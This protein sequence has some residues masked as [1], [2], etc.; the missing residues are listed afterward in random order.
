MAVDVSVLGSPSLLGCVP[1]QEAEHSCRVVRPEWAPAP[2]VVAARRIEPRVGGQRLEGPPATVDRDAEDARTEGQAVSVPLD[3]RGDEVEDGTESR[4]CP[5]DLEERVER[6]NARTAA[7]EDARQAAAPG[8]FVDA[9]PEGIGELP[10]AVRSSVV[11]P[12]RSSSA[13]RATARSRPSE[14]PPRRMTGGW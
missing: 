8:G 9:P 5:Q 6:D 4:L 7:G 13:R 14:L 12:R 11:M 10:G 2:N 1:S 3:Q